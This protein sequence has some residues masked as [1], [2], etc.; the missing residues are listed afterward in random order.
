MNGEEAAEV[1]ILNDKFFSMKE[2]NDSLASLSNTTG[3]FRNNSV[4]AG[5]YALN[6][7]INSEGINSSLANFQLDFIP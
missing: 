3:F 5:A 7:S 6:S 1:E 2:L 4:E